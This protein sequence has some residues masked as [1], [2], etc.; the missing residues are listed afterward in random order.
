MTISQ[1]L[2]VI[3][4]ILLNFVF[5]VIK[6]CM[7]WLWIAVINIVINQSIFRSPLIVKPNN[8][9][10]A[11]WKDF[12]DEFVFCPV[13][14]ILRIFFPHTKNSHAY[15]YNVNDTLS[16]IN[17]HDIIKLQYFIIHNYLI[18]NCWYWSKSSYDPSK[19]V[20]NTWT[21]CKFLSNS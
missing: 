19:Y 17:I 5:F 13:W 18:I 15:S 14:E 6:W 12:V 4:S 11:P 10:I 2:S 3:I 9:F 16:N 7:L 1:T 21:L 8:F 20:W